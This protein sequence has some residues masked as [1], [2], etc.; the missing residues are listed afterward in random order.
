MIHILKV[1]AFDTRQLAPLRLVNRALCDAAS[2]P[3]FYRLFAC[4]SVAAMKTLPLFATNSMHR[5]LMT[6]N[7]EADLA[8]MAEVVPNLTSLDSQFS[9]V[10][11]GGRLESAS[12][13]PLRELSM[14]ANVEMGTDFLRQL[15][16]LECLQVTCLGDVASIASLPLLT[17]LSLPNVAANTGELM[18]ALA[19]APCT[20]TLEALHLEVLGGTTVSPEFWELLAEFSSLSEFRLVGFVHDCQEGET[21]AFADALAGLP[22]LVVLDLGARKPVTDA[23]LRCGLPSSLAVLGLGTC[24][25]FADMLAALP[26]GLVALRVPSRRRHSAIEIRAL[27]S[28]CPQLRALSLKCDDEAVAYLASGKFDR[29]LVLNHFHFGKASQVLAGAGHR[30]GRLR[31]G[32]HWRIGGG[33]AFEGKAAGV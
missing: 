32:L 20:A 28:H 15:T 10:V 8:L 24:G 23:L 18:S 7:E 27:L 25:D 29:S 13:A 11:S 14:T 31:I 1:G 19:S 9:R 30:V 2:D 5:L 26:P 17:R 12:L 4:D 21:D 22:A 3:S 33:V 6:G 16:N